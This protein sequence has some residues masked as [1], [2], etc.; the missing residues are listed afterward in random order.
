MVLSNKLNSKKCFIDKYLNMA[1]NDLECK[2]CGLKIPHR[3][4]L[5]TMIWLKKCSIWVFN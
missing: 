4:L 2:K 5:L 3:T 1:D